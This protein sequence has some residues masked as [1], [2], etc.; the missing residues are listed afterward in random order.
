MHE[1]LTDS[2]VVSA[3]EEVMAKNMAEV[4]N[5]HYPG[6]LWAVNVQGSVVNVFNFALSGRWGFTLRIPEQFS[7]SDFDRQVMRA[8]G[9]LLERYRLARGKFDE[10]KY[11]RLRT[12]HAGNLAF[13]A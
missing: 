3:T 4:L 10:D 2:P 11:A 12:D 5:R 6:Y 1:V 8:G 7:A 13:D 9:E